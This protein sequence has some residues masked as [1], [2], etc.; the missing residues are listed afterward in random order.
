M[1]LRTVRRVARFFGPRTLWFCVADNHLHQVVEA[2]PAEVSLLRRNLD[3]VLRG[4]TG[5][6][7]DLRFKP[8]EEQSH[9]L[10]CWPYVRGN[11][12]HHGLL[13]NEG[14]GIADIVGARLVP[15]FDPRRWERHIPR[16]TLAGM[17]EAVDFPGIE[18]MP[19]AEVRA[20]GSTALVRA[21]AGA[22][23]WPEIESNLRVMVHARAA[24]IHI[25]GQA[26]IAAGEIR[27]ALGI[28]RSTAHRLGTRRDPALE[29]GILRR[30]AFDRVTGT[31]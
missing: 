21:A 27:H 11:R 20:H 10:S 1:A 24:A 23:G 26:G 19:K 31:R 6:R 22:I 16:R 28:S 18:P 3:F 29:E 5:Q 25:A 12:E 4:L 30:L 17:L 9:L 2:E 7:F 14:S 13:A 15:G 8:V